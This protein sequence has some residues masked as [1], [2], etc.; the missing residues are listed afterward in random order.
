MK[1]LYVKKVYDYDYTGY[2]TP[3]GYVL[4]ESL[5]DEEYYAKFWSKELAEKTAKFLG[6]YV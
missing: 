2:K 4:V 3:D 5:K 1:K 6:K